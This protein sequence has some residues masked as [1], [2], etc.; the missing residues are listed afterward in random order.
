MAADQRGPG[1]GHPVTVDGPLPLGSFVKLC[2][3]VGTGG[4]AKLL[5][6]NGAVSLNGVPE[7]RRARRVV[8]G[9]VVQIEDQRF[10][11]VDE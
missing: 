10:V 8:P 3:V 7:T 11:A 4:Q 1:R 9:D 6:Q 2:G 5:I